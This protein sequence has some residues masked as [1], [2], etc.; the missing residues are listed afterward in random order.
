MVPAV[1]SSMWEA[2]TADVCELE[3]S[4]GYIMSSKLRM[5]DPVSKKGGGVQIGRA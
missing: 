2:K 4:L 5:R 3:A 1:N